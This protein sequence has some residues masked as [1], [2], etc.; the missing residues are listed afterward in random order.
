MKV[1]QMHPNET[2]ILVVSMFIFIFISFNLK[3]FGLG[4]Y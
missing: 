4:T 2:M 3:I 1:C